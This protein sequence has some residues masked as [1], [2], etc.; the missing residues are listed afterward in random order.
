M[1]TVFTQL[2]ARVLLL[3]TLV[4]AAAVLVHGY[5]STGDG[6]SAGVI[7][8]TGFL[9]Q[10]LAFGYRAVERRLPVL[11]FAPALAIAGLLLALL[12][13]FV[14]VVLGDPIMTHYPRAGEE[15]IHA[16]SIEMLT[17]VLFDVGVFLIVVGFIVTAIGTIARLSER[18]I[19]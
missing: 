15:V 2:I 7:A 12:V 19:P 4:I 1:T 10:Y 11:R 3:P 17:A 8:A 18:R 14:P 16:G 13:V 5:A 6:F 9:I